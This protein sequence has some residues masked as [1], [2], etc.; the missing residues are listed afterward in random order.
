VKK[1][2]LYQLLFS[3]ALAGD[4][5]CGNMMAFNFYSG[6]H[7]LGITEGRP[8]FVRK[9]DSKFDLSN[10]MRMHFYSALCVIKKGLN[11][12]L[13]EENVD[14]DRITAHGGLF[15]V[16][17]VAQQFLAEAIDAPI[18]VLDTAGEGGAWGMALLASYLFE[19]EKMTFEEYLEKK[20][21]AGKECFLIKPTESGVKS[22]ERYYQAFDQC[23]PIEIQAIR[24]LK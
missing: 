12:L 23:L 8:L 19:K 3:L 17:G 2:D 10:F 18:A 6:E 9:P 7:I 1:N 4:P 24:S 15:K 11:I 5:D 21:F 22:F 16:K 14:I 13:Q 20:V